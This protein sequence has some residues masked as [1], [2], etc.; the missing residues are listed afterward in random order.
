MSGATHHGRQHHAGRRRRHRPGGAP[1]GDEPVGDAEPPGVGDAVP[2]PAVSSNYAAAFGSHP[3]GDEAGVNA[4]CNGVGAGSPTGDASRPSMTL[5]SPMTYGPAGFSVPV[6]TT[7]YNPRYGQQ[8]T[9]MNYGCGNVP[10][11]PMSYGPQSYGYAMNPLAPFGQQSGIGMGGFQSPWTLP[12]HQVPLQPGDLGALPRHEVPLQPG[13]LGALPRHEVPLHGPPGVSQ[14]VPPGQVRQADASGRSAISAGADPLQAEDPWSRYVQTAPTSSTTAPLTTGQQVAPVASAQEFVNGLRHGAE[15][16]KPQAV[17]SAFEA[18]G[19]AMPT[20][21]TTASAAYPEEWLKKLVEALSGDKRA[22]VPPWSGAPSGL[23]SWLKQLGMWEQETTIPRARWGIKLYSAL[24][25]EAR[26]IADVVPPEVLT[27]EGGYSAILTTL[28]ARYKPYLEAIGPQSVDNFIY[29]G[30]R[31][32]GESFAS[33]LSRKEVAK[34]EMEAQLGSVMNPLIAG[35]ILLRQ[36]A[37]SDNQMQ[38]MALKSNTLLSYEQVVNALRPLDRLETL[39]KSAGLPGAV[40]S[41]TQRA[42]LQAG[43]ETAGDYE[44]EGEEEDYVTESEESDNLLY[45]EDK[46]FDETEAIYVQAYNDVRKDLKSRRKE[47]GFVRHGKQTGKKGA[48]KK[49]KGRGRGFRKDGGRAKDEHIKG[50]EAELMARTRC[51]ACQEL[52]HISRNC[53]HKNGSKPKK[54]NFV[55]V[56]TSGSSTSTYMIQNKPEVFPPKKAT[57]LRAIYAG[58]RVRTHEGVIDTAAEEAV[59]GSQSFNGMIE[60]LRAAGLRPVPVRRPSA[61]CAGIG[62]QARLCGAYDVPTSIAG[63]L[64]ILRFTVIQDG[65]GPEGFVTPPLIPVSYLETV[66]AQLDMQNDTYA[67]ADGHSA[68]MRRLP[69]GHRAIHMFDFEQTPWKLPPKF[70]VNNH[71]PFVLQP[72]SSHS[73]FGGGGVSSGV[74]GIATSG[75]L[76]TSSSSSTSGFPPTV[77]R[78]PDAGEPMDDVFFKNYIEAHVLPGDEP[79][80]SRS[81]SGESKA[82]TVAYIDTDTE[83][84]SARSLNELVEREQEESSGQY[85]EDPVLHPEQPVHPGQP[86]HSELPRRVEMLETPTLPVAS[87]GDSEDTFESGVSWSPERAQP[88]PARFLWFEHQEE[89]SPV[90]SFVN[91]MNETTP[92]PEGRSVLFQLQDCYGQVRPLEIQEGWRRRLPVPNHLQSIPTVSLTGR[93]KVTMVDAYGRQA[94]VDDNWVERSHRTMETPWFGNVTFY[95][96]PLPPRRDDEGDSRGPSPQDDDDQD[97]DDELPPGPPGQAHGTMSSSSTTAPQPSRSRH[98][99]TSQ[100]RPTRREKKVRVF[101]CFQWIIQIMMGNGMRKLWSL[102]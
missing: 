8:M 85:E 67:T 34:Q 92:L 71:D 101:Q 10:L 64:G 13:D 75:T 63:V 78:D 23:R 7:G 33:F 83:R 59:V 56:G 25:E 35:R 50:T 93:R 80:K 3:Q 72:R 82:A 18:L 12:R 74:A 39:A 51:F 19:K 100:P 26:R 17:G 14:Q 24:G 86:V 22:V 97:Q 41:N 68:P 77:A 47:R 54:G 89:D 30:D 84:P 87:P 6:T 4:G 11:A 52:G 16:P 40:A 62:G 15:D 70:Q 61:Q 36:A 81:R 27:G 42:F 98:L 29:T 5:M 53:P 20:S 88:R 90:N 95:E 65:E 76:T 94:T 21:P 49:P 37:L 73:F 66:G 69:S 43:D 102:T 28:M 58:V 32:R 99:A 46:E 31:A 57:L 60:E 55:T 45:F 2:Q 1:G 44:E 91:E 38:M 96:T 79:P 9:G 48:N